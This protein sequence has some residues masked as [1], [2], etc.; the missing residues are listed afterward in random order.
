MIVLLLQIRISG[1]QRQG[2]GVID[3]ILQLINRRVSCSGTVTHHE[4]LGFGKLIS[5]TH[6]RQDRIE[7]QSHIAVNREFLCIQQ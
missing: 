1:R 2:I 6:I 3:H 5:E 4:V 7:S